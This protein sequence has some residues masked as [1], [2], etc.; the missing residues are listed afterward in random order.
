MKLTSFT[1]HNSSEQLW[2]CIVVLQ[3]Y[4]LKFLCLH[5]ITF[6]FLVTKTCQVSSLDEKVLPSSETFHVSEKCL[7]FINSKLPCLLQFSL[8]FIFLLWV[9]Q[10]LLESNGCCI[11]KVDSH[12]CN[13][14]MESLIQLIMNIQTSLHFK[15]LISHLT[16]SC[17]TL[18]LWHININSI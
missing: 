5:L 13:S 8:Y 11:L 10:K 12:V 16:I 1:L 14:F 9:F 3:E 2:F 18:W 15:D 17:P 7:H 6:K 4:T